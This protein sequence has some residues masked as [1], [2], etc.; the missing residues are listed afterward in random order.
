MRKAAEAN[1]EI[2]EA[3]AA[4]EQESKAVL[5]ELADKK[6]ELK[7]LHHWMEQGVSKVR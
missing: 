5:E 7:D 4:I 3:T 6:R 2:I 1:E